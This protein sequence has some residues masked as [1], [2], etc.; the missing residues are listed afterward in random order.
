MFTKPKAFTLVELLVVIA[1]IGILIALLLPAVQAAREAA[2]RS[3]CTNN[4]KQIGLAMHNYHDTHHTLP[5]GCLGWQYG[6]FMVWIMPYMEQGSAHALYTNAGMYTSTA[7]R[8]SSPVNLPVTGQRYAAFTCPSSAQV[9]KLVGVVYHNYV[10]NV[11]NTASYC[12]GQLQPD[13]SRGGGPVP[14]YNGVTFLGAPFLQQGWTGIENDCCRFADVQDGLS[15]TLCASETI[16]GVSGPPG[17][18]DVRG[19]TFY[20]PNCFFTTYATPNSKIPDMTTLPDYCNNQLNPKHPCSSGQTGG[21][22]IL[23]ASARSEHPGGVNAVLTDGSVQF[24][25]NTIDLFVWRGLGTT[26]G[27]ETVTQ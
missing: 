12:P 21:V 5:P 26:H 18:Y 20:G 22:Y 6:T 10:V 25:S 2:R 15:N 24:F 16:Q 14:L 27:S 3:Q 19:F 11:G 23:T 8:Y 9:A 13:G 1:I 17:P 7:T 4:L